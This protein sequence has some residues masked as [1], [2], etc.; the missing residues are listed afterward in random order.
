MLDN[1]MSLKQCIEVVVPALAKIN[2]AVGRDLFIFD[3]TV[4]MQTAKE[5]ARKGVLVVMGDSGM[6][7]STLA[8]TKPSKEDKEHPECIVNVLIFVNPIVWAS[9]FPQAVLIHEFVHALGGTH[10]AAGGA[11]HSIMTPVVMDISWADHLTAFDLAALRMVY[12]N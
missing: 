7:L 1:D 8:M 9:E 3:G 6:P 2:K 4:D 12:E 5:I 11:Y 10:A